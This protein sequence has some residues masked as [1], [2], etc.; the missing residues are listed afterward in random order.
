MNDELNIKKNDLLKKTLNA[1]YLE[2]T[3][4]I[5][6]SMEK[7]I[8]LPLSKIS[9]LGV[10][11]EP[12]TQIMQSV[13]SGKGKSGIYYVNTKG[14]Q[15]FSVSDS[16]YIASLKNSNGSVGGGQANM[17][18]IPCNPAMLCMAAVLM[19]IEKKL[20]NIYE[21]QKDILLYLEQKDKA[22]LQGD[23]N[24]L[25]D[26]MNNYKY[27]FD[28]EKYKTNKHIQVQEIKRNAEQNILFYREKIGEKIR[29]RKLLHSDQKANIILDNLK[30][31]FKD[32]QLALYLYAFSGF[33]EVMLLENFDTGYID[34]VTWQICE[35]SFQYR[36]LYSE[37]Y[38]LME[39]YYKSSVQSGLVKGL[40]KA[41]KMIGNT[42]A[43]VPV[44]SNSQLDEVL[45]ESGEKLNAYLDN[46]PDKTMQ[47][48]IDVCD[49]VTTPF[50]DNLNT[51]KLLYNNETKYYI[52]NENI[53]FLLSEE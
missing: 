42:I 20:D 4:E 40:S 2:I 27:N 6:L 28:N 14:K 43:K 17:T 53:Y 35:H 36:K 26:I 10:A 3:P 25:S 48:L 1:E 13:T 47:K 18:Q 49:N 22:K 9:S 15:M 19:S 23:L 32:Y 39:D 31:Q 12:L 52:D 33:A 5:N 41:S 30:T 8:R 37:C 46:K 7:A 44:I 45:I 29:K 11:F 16:K 50:V 38:D 34:S 51:V 21:L 24:V